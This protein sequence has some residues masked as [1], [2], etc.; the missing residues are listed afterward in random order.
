MNVKHAVCALMLALVVGL[1]GVLT[2]IAPA[3]AAPAP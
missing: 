2:G 3:N 1:G